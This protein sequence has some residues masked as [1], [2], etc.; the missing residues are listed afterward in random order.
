VLEA[1]YLFALPHGI[2]LQPDLQWI[3]TPGGGDGATVDD[4]LIGTIRVQIA[5]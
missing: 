3:G 1:F 2:T 4:A 5:F